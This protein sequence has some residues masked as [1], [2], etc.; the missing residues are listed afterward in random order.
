[1][2]RSLIFIGI[3]MSKVCTP[4][5]TV[6]EPRGVVIAVLCTSSVTQP[7]FVR[8]D[9]KLTDGWMWM[10]WSKHRDHMT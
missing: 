1:M 10:V 3:A 8:L 7:M 5:I 4:C 6:K 9:V 2:T